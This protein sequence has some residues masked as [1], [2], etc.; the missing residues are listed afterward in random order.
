MTKMIQECGN[1]YEA[2]ACIVHTRPDERGPGHAPSPSRRAYASTGYELSSSTGY[3]PFY[4]KR[5]RAICLNRSRRGAR[6]PFFSA[7]FALRAL[8]EGPS[9]V[10]LPRLCMPSEDVLLVKGG[11]RER[12]RN[13]EWERERESTPFFSA[14]FALRALGEGPS[15][16]A[17][18]RTRA[19]PGGPV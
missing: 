18:P 7:R 9:A 11:E 17:L 16:V 10:A 1:F 15:A 3:E 2:R 8:G 6:T 13:R 19:P 12:E 14:R 4:K 5:L